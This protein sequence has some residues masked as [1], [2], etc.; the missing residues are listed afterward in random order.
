M[1]LLLQLAVVNSKAALLPLLLLLLQPRRRAWRPVGHTAMCAAG[2]RHWRAVAGKLLP[3]AARRRSPTVLHRPMLPVLLLVPVMVGVWL[4]ALPAAIRTATPRV[5]SPHA[6][7]GGARAASKE[8]RRVAWGAGEAREVHGR[9]WLY[10]HAV[11]LPAAPG[12]VVP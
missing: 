8:R 6:R 2:V 9:S 3:P 1:L 12:Q 4:P 10:G 5:A 7:L 11:R